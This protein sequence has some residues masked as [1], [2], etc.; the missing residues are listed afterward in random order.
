MLDA[1]RIALSAQSPAVRAGLPRAARRSG[2]V[3]VVAS[4][5]GWTFST[6]R[7]EAHPFATLA[8]GEAAGRALAAVMGA[9]GAFAIVVL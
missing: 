1:T 9:P 6:D 7:A 3:Y 5:S 4:P 2:R 8:E